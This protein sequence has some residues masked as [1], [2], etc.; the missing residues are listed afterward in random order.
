VKAPASTAPRLRCADGTILPLPLARWLDDPDPDDL[1]LLDLVGG[2]VLDVGCGPGRMVVAL[3]HRGVPAL[4]VEIAPTAVRLGRSRGAAILERSVFDH[5]PGTGR[6]E[7]VLVL[8]GTIGIG[9]NPRR[10]LGRLRSLLRR[11]G[12]CFVELE[13]PGCGLARVAA[14]IET[15]GHASPWFPWARVGSDAIEDVARGEGLVVDTRWEGDGRWF[16]ALESA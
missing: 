11:G 2:P 7:T 12:R 14:R 5:V 13:P 8:D 6:W 16:A 10:L 3:Q 9:G 1:A 15:A 4:G